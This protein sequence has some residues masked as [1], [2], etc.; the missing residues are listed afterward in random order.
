MAILFACPEL[1]DKIRPRLFTLEQTFG[2]TH[3]AHKDF[4]NA[5]IKGF[6][7]H[8]YSVQW[9]IVPL[10]EY[11]LPQTRK[12]LVMI[13]ACP[14]EQL[15]PWPPAT[16]SAMPAKEGLKPFVT[17]AEAIRNLNGRRVTLHDV[18]GARVRNEP[19][20]DGN[21]PFPKTITCGGTGGTS[22][23]SG[24]RDFTVREI[25]CLQGFPISYQ[26]EGNKTAIKKQI[27]NAFPP[28]VVKAFYGYFRDWLQRVDGVRTPAPAQAPAPQVARPRPVVDRHQRGT[29]ASISL[30]VE[31]RH[32]VNGNLNEDEALQ[33]A[34]QES[35]RAAGG[36]I[37]ISDDEEEQQD[38]PVAAVAP[39][40]E[41]M[42]IAPPSN[43]ASRSRSRS[44]TLGRSPGPSPGPGPSRRATKSPSQKRSLDLMHDGDVDE[45]MEEESPPKRER[46]LETGHQESV[47]DNQIPSR[48]PRYAGPRGTYT[49][50]A[51]DEN[52][53]IGQSKSGSSQ[54]GSRDARVGA[55]GS[56]PEDRDAHRGTAGDEIE[57]EDSAIDWLTVF[58]QA[59]MAGNSGNEVWTF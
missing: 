55:G 58:S 14:G 2:L 11:G 39:L 21:K 31:P 9:K 59:R 45:V 28:C 17:E 20:R 37:D 40:L 22:H 8:G 29:P 57:R 41:R 15:P 16:H 53:A 33:L 34:L 30:V 50:D 46:L 52:V 51:D 35:R 7:C 44:I 23:F 27:G 43:R 10:V 4:L 49:H 13:G 6:T 32:H 38:S 42:S 3:D 5:L 48:L 47:D 26:F 56:V 24:S 25:A 12:R 19:P 1:I 36:V 54:N 18:A